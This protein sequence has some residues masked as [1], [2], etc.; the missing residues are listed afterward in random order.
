MLKNEQNCRPMCF[1][2]CQDGR[3]SIDL[4]VESDNIVCTWRHCIQWWDRA[5]VIVPFRCKEVDSGIS[6]GGC[7]YPVKHD[8]AVVVSRVL[9]VS[10]GYIWLETGDGLN[11]LR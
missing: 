11:M 3:E 4:H 9:I 2:G 1:L 6:D 7:P 10:A 8:V 5:H